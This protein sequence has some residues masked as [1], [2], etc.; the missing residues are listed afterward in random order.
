M[1][2]K[3]LALL[4]VAAALAGC[5]QSDP[6]VVPPVSEDGRHRDP[7]EPTPAV[8]APDCDSSQVDAGGSVLARIRCDGGDGMATLD[9]EG[10]V[11]AGS[12]WLVLQ[13][14]EGRLAQGHATAEARDGSRQLGALHLS[15]SQEDG[16]EARVPGSASYRLS[17]DL[18]AWSGEWVEA[19][20]ECEAADP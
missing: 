18:D 16:K 5:M 8:A 20:L 4:V 7:T 6:T 9:V 15:A 10:C 1:L 14:E 13:S 19:V 3:S 12:A 17:L 2:R 11:P